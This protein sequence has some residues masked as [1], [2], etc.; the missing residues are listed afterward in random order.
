MK[1][2][3]LAFLSA[4]QFLTRLPIPDPGWEEGRLDRAAKWFPLV[5]ALIGLICGLVAVAAFALNLSA[6]VSILIGIMVGVLVTGALHEDGLA[7]TA[8]GLGGGRDRAHRLIIMKDSSIG[9]YAAIALI[10]AFGFRFLLYFPDVAMIDGWVIVLLFIAAHCVGRAGMLGIVW[11][12]N[13]VRDEEAAKVS[14]LSAPTTLHGV[15]IAAA[16]VLAALLPLNLY[17]GALTGI[18]IGVLMAGLAVVALRTLYL[19]KLGGWTGDTAGATQ[20]IGEIAFLT[21]MAAWI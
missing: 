11:S 17:A 21:G 18:G 16:T 5:G 4:I 3:W 1:N 14:P 15:G 20:I 2:E 6:S 7:D 13:Y 12:L 10:L 8:D 19:R 9:S